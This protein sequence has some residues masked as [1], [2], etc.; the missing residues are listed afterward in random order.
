M[1]FEHDARARRI[2]IVLSI[3]IFVALLR[4][5]Y[6]NSPIYRYIAESV[7]I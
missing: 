6:K 3:S 7:L 2:V 5:S 4:Y 1:R